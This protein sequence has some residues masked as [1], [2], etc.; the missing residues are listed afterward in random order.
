[1]LKKY[2]ESNFVKGD[3]L[4]ASSTAIQNWQQK[5]E[6]VKAMQ[7]QLDLSRASLAEIER[8]LANTPRTITDM[9][10]LTDGNQQNPVYVEL[11]NRRGLIETQLEE[12]L[13]KHTEDHPA[14]KQI[15]GALKLI[16]ERIAQMNGSSTKKKQPNDKTEV[17]E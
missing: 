14:V 10:I 7:D 6:T 16:D 13:K 11:V 3:M 4:T 2:Q 8:Q 15:R 12:E 9:E 17:R 1:K 5:D